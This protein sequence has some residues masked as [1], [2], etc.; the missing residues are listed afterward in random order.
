MTNTVLTAELKKFESAKNALINLFYE[1]KE[2][3]HYSHGTH[4]YI[5]LQEYSNAVSK[6]LRD[7]YGW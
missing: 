4:E 3:Q 2:K 7:D 6:L 1:L 5:K